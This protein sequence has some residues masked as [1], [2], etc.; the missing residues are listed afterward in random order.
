MTIA[1]I[2][3][4]LDQELTALARGISLECLVC[5][6]FVLHDGEDVIC[7]ECHSRWPQLLKDEKPALHWE[8]QAG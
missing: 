4:T 6:E 8:S 5:G 7:P 3:Q 2:H 1:F